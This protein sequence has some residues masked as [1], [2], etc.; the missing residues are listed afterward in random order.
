MKTM[1]LAAMLFLSTTSFA[2]HFMHSFGAGLNLVTHKAEQITSFFPY[3]TEKKNET[4]FHG[5]ADYFPRY[6]ISEH[7]NSSVSVGLP[8]SLGLGSAS[9]GF[10]DN[11]G[12]Y[13]AGDASLGA[14]FNSGYK[15]TRENESNFGYFIGG[16][17]SYGHL[18]IDYGNGS[19]SINTYGPMVHAGVRIPMKRQNLSIGLFVRQGLEDDKFKTYGLKLLTDL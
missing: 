19:M 7:E 12:L 3:T 5:S 10:S 11:S 13:F 14:Y 18:S 4:L 16:G 8:I 1:T 9:D 6:N 2:Q 17:F 15:S